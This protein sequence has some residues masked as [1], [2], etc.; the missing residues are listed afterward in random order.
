MLEL[1]LIPILY[2]IKMKRLNYFHH[3]LNTDNNS[4]ARKVL[5]EQMKKPYKSDWI[6]TLQEDLNEFQL[7]MTFDQISSA[8]KNHWKKTVKKACLDT[9]FKFLMSQKSKQS[10]GKEIEYSSL[11]MQNY[12]MAGNGLQLI[13]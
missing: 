13:I 2:I 10:K 3:L 8:S 1:G 6:S 12:L 4:I 7:N 9:A 5:F 11:Q